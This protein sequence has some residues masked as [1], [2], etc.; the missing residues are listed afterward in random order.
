MGGILRIQINNS[1]LQPKGFWGF[2]GTHLDAV[3]GDRHARV[4][5]GTFER[6]PVG[7]NGC[8]KVIGRCS[9]PLFFFSLPINIL[10]ARV[11][12]LAQG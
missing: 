10:F 12:L 7:K 8:N 11:V 9:V 5:D 6:R 4:A 2:G 1:N 3:A